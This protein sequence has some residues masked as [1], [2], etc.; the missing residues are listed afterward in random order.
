MTARRFKGGCDSTGV[1]RGDKTLGVK[2]GDKTLGVKRG[3]N[4]KGKGLK[5]GFDS[6]GVKRGECDPPNK[7]NCIDRRQSACNSVK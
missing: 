1:K 6:P 7:H 2:R 4:S 3:I 5:G